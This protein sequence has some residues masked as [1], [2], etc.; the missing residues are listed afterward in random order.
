LIFLFDLEFLKGVQSSKALTAEI[1]LSIN[2]LS[3]QQVHIF[4]PRALLQV[5]KMQELKAGF[6]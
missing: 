5:V 2:E 3:R 1:Y 6:V 4:F